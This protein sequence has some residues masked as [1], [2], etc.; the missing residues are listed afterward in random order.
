MSSLCD[1]YMVEV[2]FFE[3][4]SWFLFDSTGWLEEKR[5]V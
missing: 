2:M 5:Q 3:L 1:L 4:V